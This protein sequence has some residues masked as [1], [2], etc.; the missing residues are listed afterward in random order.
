MWQVGLSQRSPGQRARGDLRLGGGGD[1]HP[2]VGL[3]PLPPSARHPVVPHSCPPAWGQNFTWGWGAADSQQ[4]RWAWGRG[5][6]MLVAWPPGPG[7][8]RLC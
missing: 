1:C 3:A 8:G 7:P 6:R 4:C 5:V 2:A